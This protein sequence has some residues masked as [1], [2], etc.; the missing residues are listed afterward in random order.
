[1][2]LLKHAAASDRRA[3]ADL[4]RHRHA[5]HG[6]KNHVNL[7]RTGPVQVLPNAEARRGANGAQRARVQLVRRP[8][9]GYWVWGLDAV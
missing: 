5:A 3:G 2:Y 4:P 6:L 7:R 1:M 8:V 9:R